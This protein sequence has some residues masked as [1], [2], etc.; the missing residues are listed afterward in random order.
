MTV[1]EGENGISRVAVAFKSSQGVYLSRTDRLK[2]DRS[3]VLELNERQRSWRRLEQALGN[4]LDENAR[5]LLAA[6]RQDDFD[7]ETWEKL[8]GVEQEDIRF[9]AVQHL[10][11]QQ[12]LWAGTMAR[13]DVGRGCFRWQ[14]SNNGVRLSSAEHILAGWSGGSCLQLAFL[15]NDVFATTAFGGILKR[16]VAP[17]QRNKEVWQALPR[18]RLPHLPVPLPDQA[19]KTAP[20]MPLHA[21][22]AR[23]EQHDEH[24]HETI[25]VG[26]PQGLFRSFDRGESYHSAAKQTFVDPEDVI[27][28]PYNWLFVSGRHD[29]TI[30]DLTHLERDATR[31]EA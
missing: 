10:A 25:L 9:L 24:W 7:T 1:L 5:Q 12:Y 19:N 14:F 8:G 26:G 28:L 20:L 13:A 2:P 4:N 27:S 30:R 21:I 23:R 11:N 17:G 6:L 15:G 22:A 31:G 18:E 29:V 16:T 3:R